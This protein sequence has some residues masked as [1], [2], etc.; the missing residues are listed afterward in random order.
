MKQFPFQKM[1]LEA[2]GFYDLINTWAEMQLV[3]TKDSATI[4]GDGY[5]HEILE[6]FTVLV[7]DWEASIPLSKESLDIPEGSYDLSRMGDIVHA[8]TN[9]QA[10]PL[11]DRPVTVEVVS[12]PEEG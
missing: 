12:M 5:A 9:R 2:D 8:C 7:F 4:I 3:V 6:A 11:P 1:R 10:Y